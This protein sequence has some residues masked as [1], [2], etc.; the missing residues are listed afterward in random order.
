[1]SSSAVAY[2]ELY[3]SPED[4]LALGLCVSASRGLRCI[5]TSVP[6][7]AASLRPPGMGRSGAAGA[8][9]SS[10]WRSASGSILALAWRNA[11]AEGAAGASSHPGA[12][13]QPSVPVPMHTSALITSPA[14]IRRVRVKSAPGRLT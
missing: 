2:T 1:M 12:S 6:S 14:P 10:S 9:R 3:P 13:S 4:P 11:E 8:K 7:T 5:A